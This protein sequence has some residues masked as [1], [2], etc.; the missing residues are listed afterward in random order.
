MVHSAISIRRYYLLYIV[1]GLYSFASRI[2]GEELRVIRSGLPIRKRGGI[3]WGADKKTK[4]TLYSR[5]S[6]Y[7]QIYLG[8]PTVLWS[9]KMHPVHT[10]VLTQNL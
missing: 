3:Q 7:I 8:R 5:S 2:D 10:V 9:E 1:C 4:V 6:K